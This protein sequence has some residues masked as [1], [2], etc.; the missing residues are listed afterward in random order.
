MESGWASPSCGGRLVTKVILR[1][2]DGER[3]GNGASGLGVGG[4]NGF[5]DGRGGETEGRSESERA[6]EQQIE[7]SGVADGSDCGGE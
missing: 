3:D 6:P 2:V 1:P 4:L 5:G 7:D